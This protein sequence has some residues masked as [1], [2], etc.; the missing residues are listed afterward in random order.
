[1]P[2]IVVEN[3]TKFYGRTRGVE[4][5]SLEVREGE[6]FGFLGPN[7]AG[8]T[9]AIRVLL[10]FIRPTRGR[11]TVL[12]LDAQRDSMEIRRRVGYLPG[13]PGLYDHMTGEEYLAYL[14]SFR[15]GGA[16]GGRGAAGGAGGPRGRT[17]LDQRTVAARRA[18]LSRRLDIDLGRRIKTLSRGMKQKVAIIQAFMYGAD[19]LVLDEPTSGLDPLM[20][21]VF[22]GILEE[23][24]AAGRT[25]F[26]S[27]HVLSEVERVCDRVAIIRGGRLAL[28]EVVE[29]LKKKRIKKVHATFAG[30][31]E[32]GSLSLPGVRDLTVKPSGSGT[33]AEFRVE[34]AAVPAVVRVLGSLPLAD[35]VIENPSL[36]D[37]FFEFFGPE[38]AAEARPPGGEARLSGG[39]ARLSGGEG[40]RGRA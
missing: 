36:E 22:Y 37:I 31:I 13:E 11:A 32:T 12:G 18:D 9:T 33:V 7:G 35:M 40:R 34:G 21:H 25:V 27:S 5:L 8:K 20:Q 39:E 14:A 23:E 6:V 10:D 15:C 19:L 3:L 38:A 1:L 16:R 29:D 2:A 17:G 26:M 4:E 24:R 30:P 28:L